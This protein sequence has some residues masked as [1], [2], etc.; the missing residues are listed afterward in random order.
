MDGYELGAEAVIETLPGYAGS[1][2]VR[3]GNAANRQV[4][5]DVFGPIADLIA[6]VADAPRR[7]C[8]TTTSRSWRHGR[9]GRAPLARARPRH[10]GGPPA[11]PAPHLLQGDVL[12]DRRPG[13][14]VRR[15][16]T[17]RTVP[18]WVAAARPDRR[19][20][21]GARAGTRR[22]AHTRVAYGDEEMDASSLWIG[23]SGLLA[24]DDPRFLATVLAVEAELR[25]GPI[26]YRYR[27]DDGLP[28]REGGFH[29][30]T[31]WLI[32]AYLR[33]GRRAD[34][35]ELFAQMIDSRRP[36][37]AAAGAV[38]PADR[39]RAGQPPAGVQ[40][41]RADPLRPAAGHM[42]KRD[43]LTCADVAVR[44]PRDT[45]LRHGRE[46]V[47]DRAERR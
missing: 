29:I 34:A 13:A 12:D 27:W 28:G 44:P 26:V 5:L 47:D 19:E 21:A 10:L 8:G 1:R 33:T 43:R 15:A 40:P 2:P 22:S 39:A 46:R 35:E 38:R 11:A 41:P 14:A 3:V 24:D 9:G 6:A 31:A 36:D 32:E 30:C 4:Q 25:S 37:R 16:G 17:A 7:R 23:L 45:L 42:L 20:R 18:E